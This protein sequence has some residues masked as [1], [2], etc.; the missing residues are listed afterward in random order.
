MRYSSIVSLV[1][2]V[3]LLSSHAIAGTSLTPRP[4]DPVAVEIF[5]RAMERSALVR[6]LVATLES[7]NVI[8][9][10]VSTRPLPA[11]VGGTMTYVT[12]SGGYR[13][14]RIAI[15]PEMSW[16]MR[17]AIMAHE[18]RHACELAESSA[19][20]PAAVEKLFEEKGDRMGRFFETRAAV[21]TERQV[22]ME[23][24]AG[25]ALQA[26]PVVKFDH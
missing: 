22:K 19:D 16:S 2:V 10:I 5:Q 9:H 23:L 1:V 24:R 13:Y 25:R 21:D 4:L 17:T 11:G 7:S 3:L 20:D 12:S 8:V 6:S 18:L 26:E 15:R 14:V